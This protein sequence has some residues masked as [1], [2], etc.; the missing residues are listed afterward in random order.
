LFFKKPKT[1]LLEKS[2]PNVAEMKNLEHQ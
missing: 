2:I 1:N